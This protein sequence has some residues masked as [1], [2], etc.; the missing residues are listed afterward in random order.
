MEDSLGQTL[1]AGDGGWTVNRLKNGEGGA[2][3]S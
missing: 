1:N 2:G 3:G